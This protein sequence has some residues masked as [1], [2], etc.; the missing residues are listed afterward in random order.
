MFRWY[1]IF[2]IPEFEAFGLVSKTYTF[3]MDVV[4]EKDIL[5]TKGNLIGLTYDDVYLAVC[6]GL[7][8]L[9]MDDFAAYVD[10]NQDVYLGIKIAS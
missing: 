5:V 2:N 10:S 3:N 7:N 6:L 4:G 1:R 8:P 9:E